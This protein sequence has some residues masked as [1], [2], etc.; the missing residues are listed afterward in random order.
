MASVAEILTSKYNQDISKSN[1]GLAGYNIYKHPKGM[2]LQLKYNDKNLKKYVIIAKVK[3]KDNMPETISNFIEMYGS[4]DLK[5]GKYKIIPEIF[6]KLCQQHK[7]YN[8]LIIDCNVEQSRSQVVIERAGI[9]KNISKMALSIHVVA[10]IVEKLSVSKCL[11]ALEAQDLWQA[12]YRIEQALTAY[13]MPS[14][15]FQNMLFYNEAKKKEISNKFVTAYVIGSIDNAKR[16]LPYRSDLDGF[17]V[18]ANKKS[19]SNNKS[20]IDSYMNRLDGI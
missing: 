16:F 13:K 14:E 10:D 19:I 5:N 17:G 8:E 18:G 20:L 1:F 4:E 7:K 2:Q 6:N 12:M 3:I 9:R 15:L 11:T